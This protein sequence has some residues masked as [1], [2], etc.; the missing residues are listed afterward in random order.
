MSPLS[1]L[2]VRRKPWRRGLSTPLVAALLVL[3][4]AV[5]DVSGEA[6]GSDRIT[7]FQQA[8]ERYA[9]ARRLA[10][11]G[12]LADAIRETRA[13]L[14]VVERSAGADHWIAGSIMADLAQLYRRQRD[15][16]A[17][18]EFSARAAAILQAAG[19]APNRVGGLVAL[20]EIDAE[21][22]DL[23]GALRLLE[24]ASSIR[25]ASVSQDLSDLLDVRLGDALFSLGRYA[26]ARSRYAR[27]EPT[28]QHRGGPAA[29]RLD[30]SFARLDN[31]VRRFDE[32]GRRAEAARTRFL[33]AA[34]PVGVAEADVVLARIDMAR[35]DFSP[36][37]SR[38]QSAR[39]SLDS[40]GF[41]D[42]LAK[43]EALDAEATIRLLRGE[44][45]DAEAADREILRVYEATLGAGHPSLGQIYHRMGIAYQELGDYRASA[46]S[47]DRALAIFTDSL[48]RASQPYASSLAERAR[49]QRKVG[50]FEEAVSDAR[51]SVRILESLP[52]VKPYYVALAEA[53]L[54]AALKD[55]G[56]QDEAFE[57]ISKALRTMRN[58]PINSAADMLPGI[59]NLA[60]ISLARGD[61]A[62]A[63]ELIA[64]GEAI[65]KASGAT[66]GTEI[67]RTGRIRAQ[68][69]LRRDNPEAAL[70]V[71][72]AELDAHATRLSQYSRSPSFAAEFG[73]EVVENDIEV[74]LRAAEQT[75]TKEPDRRPALEAAMFL[76]TQL[77]V[78]FQAGQ[79]VNGISARFSTPD[80]RLADLIKQRR[81]LGV[82]Q[83]AADKLL[84]AALVSEPG[85]ERS[86]A[87]RSLRKQLTSIQ[88]GIS[89]VDGA[90][91]AQYPSFVA[92][93][94]PKQMDASDVAPV[95]DPDEAMLMQ[96]STRDGTYI[97]LITRSGMVV[98]KSA[99]SA[100]DLAAL[101]KTLRASV[102]VTNG[103]A[104]FDV[105]SAAA[106]YD[107][108]FRPVEQD[109]RDVK[110][111]IFV[112]NQA[113]LAIP[114]SILLRKLPLIQEPAFSDYR[115]LDFLVRVLAISV[116]PSP[117]VF[118]ALRNRTSNTTF[119]RP[120]AGF[121]DPVVDPPAVAT[122]ENSPNAR[123]LQYVDWRSAGVSFTPLPETSVELQLM[124]KFAGAG[125]EIYVGRQASEKTLK[126]L[127]LDGTRV[128]A[129]ATHG[130]LAY[131]I[132]IFSEP[133]LVLSLP[134]APSAEDDG[135]L[136]ATEIASLDL[137]SDVVILSACNTAGAA[138]RPGAPGLS[139]LTRAFFFAGAHSV[140]SSHW[141]VAS[142]A[143]VPLTTGFLFRLLQEGRPRPAEA[144][145]ASMT[146]LLDGEYGELLTHPA[147]W[148]P[149]AL[150]GE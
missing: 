62:G 6:A 16:A 108:I 122:P 67:W 102:D 60:E 79:A 89:A 75:E 85:E 7:A 128:I 125:S 14:A 78:S 18:L 31:A 95:L 5:Q 121:G 29:A 148:G 37:L 41:G 23:T 99:L 39:G 143:T 119:R 100:D 55:A 139:G 44:Y 2:P 118:V 145:Q 134:S 104:P 40:S 133:S 4:M 84:A 27:A 149:F 50:Q 141:A 36:A 117:D 42:S 132:P 1:T 150:V 21:T 94:E 136:T 124:A 28:V 140:L 96:Y 131:E 144:L 24:A 127:D 90:L 46:E 48:G 10:A 83:K 43:A 66:A 91:S 137:G 9:V 109:L 111:L 63:D 97:F 38:L 20:S 115:N 116:S 105:K 19:P 26:E 17:A 12:A 80:D 57:T 73:T 114:P 103:L 59:N 34:D 45:L 15:Y 123:T 71:M 92:Y 22:G 68:L 113:M 32:A 87:I 69:E 56:R 33:A 126:T 147:V 72:Q 64:E 52:E 53:S 93:L 106:I 88:N 146:A 51:E 129:F 70:N 138:G 81:V 107:G 82:D 110:H 77:L 58:D 8:M 120:F 47:Y 98:R 54:G 11:G 49:L 61:L 86:E 76:G 13:V 142:Q 65:F 74:F 112:P 101:V 25:D 130:L 35:M 135:F 30:L 3:T